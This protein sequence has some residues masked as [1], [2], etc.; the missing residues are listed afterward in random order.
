MR[1]QDS[2]SAARRQ[3]DCDLDRA[4]ARHS[5]LLTAS[6]DLRADVERGRALIAKLLPTGAPILSAAHEVEML[7]QHVGNLQGL[8]ALTAAHGILQRHG[9]AA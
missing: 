8:A 7:E 9:R 2:T 3:S 1:T 5:D 6:A 4:Q